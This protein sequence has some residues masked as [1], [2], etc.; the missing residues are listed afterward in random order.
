VSLQPWIGQHLVSP[1]YRLTKTI[2]QPKKLKL[3][4]VIRIYV[5]NQLCG[6]PKSAQG[7]EH[8]VHVLGLVIDAKR[9]LMVC[10]FY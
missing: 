1:G 2:H 4:A 5:G 9:Y 6:V 10:H 7:I 3:C 8:P